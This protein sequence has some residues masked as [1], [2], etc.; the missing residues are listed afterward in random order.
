MR[1]NP[2]IK[3]L[4]CDAGLIQSDG[5]KWFNIILE[6][7]GN[8]CDAKAILFVCWYIF[9]KPYVNQDV[10]INTFAFNKKDY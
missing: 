6:M 4:H 9:K 10:R 3:V 5:G 8:F 1:K 7:L 2:D